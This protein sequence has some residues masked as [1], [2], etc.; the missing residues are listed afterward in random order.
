LH[1]ELELVAFL[2]K[3]DPISSLDEMLADL[4]RARTDLGVAGYTV[5]PKKVASNGNVVFA[6]RHEVM[7]DSEGRPLSTFDVVG[8]HMVEDGRIRRFT[9]YFFAPRDAGRLGRRPAGVAPD[10]SIYERRLA[11]RVSRSRL[12]AATAGSTPSSRSISVAADISSAR[13][14]A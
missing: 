9:D 13:R 7:L 8:V 11:S 2:N 14:T 12:A 6:E 3:D 5:E 10:I 4:E 1:E